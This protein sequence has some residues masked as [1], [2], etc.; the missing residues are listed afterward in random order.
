M[1]DWTIILQWVPLLVFVVAGLGVLIRYLDS[2]RTFRIKNIEVLHNC[3][4]ENHYLGK[5]YIIEQ[6]LRSS[7]GVHIPYNWVG[8]ILKRKDSNKLFGLFKTGNK[9][10]EVSVWNDD[11]RVR[12]LLY[13][14]NS[15][16]ARYWKVLV[17]SYAL[18]ITLVSIGT[19]AFMASFWIL[20]ER[21]FEV[22]EA[23]DIVIS[24]AFLLG[25][26][27]P[28]LIFG[29]QQLNKP[30]AMNAAIEFFK[31]F[32]EKVAGLDLH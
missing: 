24:F 30:A 19:I 27:I 17:S 28:T 11:L 31:A 14:S 25:A 6:L 7:Y 20:I 2:Q 26:S 4:K 15:S 18:Y 5:S 16:D 12:C 32:D 9:Y 1:S 8:R 13:D 23:L 29:F 22:M 3:L 21:P 10:I